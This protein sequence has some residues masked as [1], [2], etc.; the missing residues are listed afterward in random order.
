MP[1]AGLLV[2]PY[3]LTGCHHNPYRWSSSMQH[4]VPFWLTRCPNQWFVC[5][6]ITVGF[7]RPPPAV[8]HGS[9]HG[10]TGKSPLCSNCLCVFVQ[11]SW[12]RS[13]RWSPNAT[14]THISVSGFDIYMIP[15]S[16]CSH[17]PPV[18]HPHMSNQLGSE[19]DK[20]KSCSF[21]N[22]CGGCKQQVWDKGPCPPNPQWDPILSPPPHTFYIQQRCKWEQDPIGE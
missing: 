3:V 9:P 2:S 17:S 6:I 14:Q 15:L 4:C 7:R 18:N 5:K 13:W 11:S 22:A 10:R 12:Q 20:E 16:C 8:G 19:G 1:D 21:V